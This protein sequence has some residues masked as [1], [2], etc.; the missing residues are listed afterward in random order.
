MNQLDRKVATRLT[1][2]YVM[3]LTLVA[4]LTVSG[5]WF[6]KR[7]IHELNGDG[8]VVNVAGRQRMLSQRLTKLAVLRVQDIPHRDTANFN[9]L[10]SLWQESHEQLREG[11]LRMEN[12]YTVRKSPYLDQMF[13][14]LQPVYTSMLFYFKKINTEI[15][16][17]AERKVALAGIL[18]QEPLFLQQMDSIVFQFDA[19]TRQRVQYL[20]RIE[21]FLTLA[22]LLV[23]VLEGLFVFRPVVGYTK[24]VIRMLTKSEEELK[25]ANEKLAV[26][27]QT[28][29]HTQEKLLRATE[30]KYQLQRT[31]ETVR[32]VALLE[33]QEEERKRFARELHDGIGQMLTGLKLHIEKIRQ[34]PFENEKQKQRFEDLRNLVQETIQSTRQVSF[35]LMPSVLSDFGLEAALQLLCDQTSRTVGLPITY[36]GTRENTRLSAAQEIGLYRITQEGLN[37]AIKHAEASLITVKMARNSTG[38]TLRIQD[39]GK[40]FEKKKGIKSPGPALIHNGIENMKTRARLLNGTFKLESKLN[41]G[42]KV[43]VKIIL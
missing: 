21:W 1:Q 32:T 7:I 35:N 9:N 38:L 23:L 37:N 5:L 41:K 15:T 6:V 3:A 33:G 4:L 36:E 29:I 42:T 39:N 14:R 24:K 31:E 13:G 18:R 34:T 26:S 11:L 17:P 20:E 8:R 28:L 43:E 2:Y 25:A 10:L 12:E 30:E 27:N 22:T 16:T 19:E 40:G